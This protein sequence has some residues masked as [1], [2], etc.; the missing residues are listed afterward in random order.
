MEIVEENE[1][2]LWLGMAICSQGKTRKT[3]R[4]KEDQRYI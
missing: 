2:G 3:G 4:K 1:D